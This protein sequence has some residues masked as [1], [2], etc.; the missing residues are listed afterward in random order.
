MSVILKFWFFYIFSTSTIYQ[1]VLI[2]C[3]ARRLKTL[4]FLVPFLHIPRPRSS[5]PRPVLF[6]TPGPLHHRLLPRSFH[7]S[8]SRTSRATTPLHNPKADTDTLGGLRRSDWP[9]TLPGVGV[10]TRPEPLLPSIRP[11]TLETPSLRFLHRPRRSRDDW[12]HSGTLSWTGGESS[13][14]E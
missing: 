11:H 6:S 13:Y 12:C 2:L 4:V 3:L 8:P 10:L 1:D 7:S 14:T 9:I 5:F